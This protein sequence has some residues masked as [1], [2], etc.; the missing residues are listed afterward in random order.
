MRAWGVNS[1][2]VMGPDWISSPPAIREAGRYDVMANVPP[3]ATTE[4][5]MIMWRNLLADRFGVVLHHE[6]RVLAASDLVVVKSGTKMKRSSLDPATPALDTSELTRDEATLDKTGCVELSDPA[7]VLYM[8][9]GPGGTSQCMAVKGQSPSQI[10]NRLSEQYRRPVID[11]TGLAGTYD[12][13]IRYGLGLK[14]EDVMEQQLGLK[15]IDS[16]ATI[17]VIVVDK[18]N[19]M[20]SEN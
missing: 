13:A 2:Q 12:F 7:I 6:S 11:K 4:Q 19:K 5:V 16:K 9:N 10:A 17:D 8:T 15:L 14:F 18:A 20:P 1:Y 3:N